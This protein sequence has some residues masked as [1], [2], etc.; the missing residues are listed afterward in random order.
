V[1]ECW[2]G[3]SWTAEWRKSSQQVLSICESS[4][5]TVGKAFQVKLVKFANLSS[6]QK[7][8]TSKNLKYLLICLTLFWL[9]HDS[10][11]YFI[12]LISSLLS[13]NVEDVIARVIKQQ[14]M[15]C[16]FLQ[17]CGMLPSS[18]S[19]NNNNGHGAAVALFP[20]LWITSLNQYLFSFLII[21][22]VTRHVVKYYN[23]K[24]F[25][26]AWL[27][28]LCEME[29]IEKLPKY[30]PCLL[31]TPCRLKQMLK[32][33]ERVQLVFELMSALVTVGCWGQG[34]S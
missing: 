25:S 11:C 2:F 22:D 7:V 4:F 6:R 19:S 21:W 29:P 3:L 12:V 32:V 18:A 10:I 17:Q 1:M 15:Y 33:F 30:K 27:S 26:F 9:L 5:K 31:G 34:G 28:L 16:T 20:L 23:F 13:Y 14:Y 24:Y 8:A